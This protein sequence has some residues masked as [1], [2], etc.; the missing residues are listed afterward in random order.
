MEW[1]KK[2]KLKIKNT[3]WPPRSIFGRALED[4]FYDILFLFR[5]FTS[6]KIE[7]V[8]GKINKFSKKKGKKFL[9]LNNK[10]FEFDFLLVCSGNYTANPN[11]TTISK[12]INSLSRNTNCKYIYNF[13]NI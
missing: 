7:L 9:V 13:L 2:N 8:L 5:K 10:N 3:D 1:S 11:S 12:K 6:I 4:K